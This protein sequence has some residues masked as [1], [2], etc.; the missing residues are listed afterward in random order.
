MR[1]CSHKD[2]ALL[3][4]V[5]MVLATLS[6]LALLAVSEQVDAAAQPRSGLSVDGGE[7]P[8]PIISCSSGS[9]RGDTGSLGAD[10]AGDL[11]A[12]MSPTTS[13][14]TAPPTARSMIQSVPAPA[15]APAP[16]VV[17][18]RPY[19][20]FL[21]CG[22]CAPH[23]EFTGCATAVASCAL[24]TR[25]VCRDPVQAGRRACDAGIRPSGSGSRAMAA[26]VSI[27]CGTTLDSF[28]KAD[29]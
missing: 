7:V 28:G 26:G 16:S 10:T 25:R 27:D 4:S 14:A 29:L 18:S 2:D 6:L 17:A 20:R 13:A 5:A 22:Q 23:D 24:T 9:S 1:A 15:P 19:P 3:A 21:V 12:P 11:G 8:H